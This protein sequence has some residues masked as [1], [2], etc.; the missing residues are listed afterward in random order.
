MA[1]DSQR[2][3]ENACFVSKLAFFFHC[4][5]PLWTAPNPYAR[6]TGHDPH[7]HGPEK[8]PPELQ[9]RDCRLYKEAPQ[10]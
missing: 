4:A 8:L 1:Q 6:V 7:G 5:D 2:H 9:A 10:E 3:L